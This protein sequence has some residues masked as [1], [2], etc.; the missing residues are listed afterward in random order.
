[1]VVGVEKITDMTGSAIEGAVA[2]TTD[3]DYEAMQG[4]TPTAQAALLAQRYLMEFKAPREALAEFPII[5]HGNAVHNPNAL[6]RKAIS[7]E[8]YER[9]EIVSDPLNLYDIAPYADGAA[10]VVL[11]RAEL[12]P[13]ELP[14]ALVR[15]IG[16]SVVIDSLS[17]HDRPDPLSFGAV[18][19]SVER[20]CRQAG[21]MPGDADF[22]ELCDATS[23]YA[24]LSLEAAGY[25]K[26]GEGWKLAASGELCPNGKLPILTLG[27]LKARGNPLGASGVYQAVEAVQQL[28][29]AA[30]A[31]QIAR[32]RLGL[33]QSLGGPAATAVTHVLERMNVLEV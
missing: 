20:A 16:S 30:G 28:R 15:I 4:L 19:A 24:L 2:A 11:T 27:G 1:M 7:R 6:Y 33:V 25:A 23:I 3:Y 26:R 13:V 18:T 22:F 29:G 5:A 14:H 12:A 31:A 8:S 17:L 21:I 9:A 32:A 10:A